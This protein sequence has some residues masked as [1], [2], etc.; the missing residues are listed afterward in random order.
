MKLLK[1]IWDNTYGLL[2]DD[3]RMAVGALLILAFAGILAELAPDESARN[4]SG[5]VLLGL[6]CVLI[7]TN[8]YAAGQNA[9]RQRVSVPEHSTN[10]PRS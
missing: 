6:V 10:Q 2:V 4:A 5:F 7:L 1:L 9:A 3:G 8:L